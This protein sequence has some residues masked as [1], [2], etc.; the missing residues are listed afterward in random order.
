MM[1]WH[2][3]KNMKIIP[4]IECGRPTSRLKYCIECAEDVK[5]RMMRDYHHDGKRA[6]KKVIEEAEQEENKTV[7]DRSSSFTWDQPNDKFFG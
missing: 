4:C 7:A 3:K 6:S 5:Q 2:K 1:A